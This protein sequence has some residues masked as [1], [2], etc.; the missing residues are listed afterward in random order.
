MNVLTAFRQ[1]GRTTR[2]LQAAIEAARAGRAVYVVAADHNHVRYMLDMLQDLIQVDDRRLLNS[3]KIETPVQL[4]NF[5]YMTLGLRGAHPN[6]KVF[7]DH[8]TLERLFPAI[9]QAF[10]EFDPDF[11]PGI[12]ARTSS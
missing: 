2:M 3:I 10:H 9:I 8:F 4:G 1:T 5:D 6:C 7:V 12:I 11:I